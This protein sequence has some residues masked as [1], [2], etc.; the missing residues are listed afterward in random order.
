MLSNK[1]VAP[2]VESIYI[3]NRKFIKDR[4]TND[5][6]CSDS[7]AIFLKETI[8]DSILTMKLYTKND[9]GKNLVKMGH[10]I[11]KYKNQR[12]EH[13]YY[14]AGILRVITKYRET[15]SMSAYNYLSE[16]YGKRWYN[17][18][19]QLEQE[20]NLDSLYRISSKE[21]RTK[22]DLAIPQQI[23][24]LYYNRKY[25]KTL[26]SNFENH[27]KDAVLKYDYPYWLIFAPVDSNCS[28]IIFVDGVTGDIVL[29]KT[30]CQPIP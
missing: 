21:A 23:Y 10:K 15:G 19:G 7:G 18:E 4:N 1:D 3:E 12:E 22:I 24:R 2:E 30:E 8:G 6:L 27:Y 17:K 13:H 25:D 26:L 11:I 20:I 16:A 28:K 5:E 9:Q 29:E 14:P